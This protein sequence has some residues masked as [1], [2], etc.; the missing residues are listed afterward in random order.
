MVTTLRLAFAEAIDNLRNNFFHTVL[1]VMGMIVGVAALVT[2]LSI[3]DGLELLARRSIADRS[4]VTTVN[5]LQ[6]TTQSLDGLVVPMATTASITSENMRAMLDELPYAATFQLYATND[7]TVTDPHTGVPMGMRYAALSLPILRDV[8]PVVIGRDLTESDEV[9]FAPVIVVNSSLARRLTQEGEL[10][11]AA[12]GRFINIEG[13][14]MEVVGVREP[15]ENEYYLQA[16]M[17]LSVLSRNTDAD[18]STK[19]YID[20][21]RVEDVRPGQT[22]IED[23][24]Q[25][26]YPQI[27]EPVEVKANISAVE[28][29]EEGF[30]LFRVVMGLLIGIAVAVG[31]LG[32]MNVLLMSI[33]NRTP[34]IGIRKATGAT[35]RRILLQFLAESVAISCIGCVFGLI[36]GALL[37]IPSAAIISQFIDGEFEAVFTIRTLAII[38][39]VAIISGIAFGTYPARRAARLDPVAAIQR[40]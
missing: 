25:G 29:L 35:P 10:A 11:Q 19:A 16:E 7:V 20:F 26:Q 33:T 40:S 15:Q 2:M 27:T 30:L 31:G 13:Q 34:E 3:I 32:L 38:S 9:N 36:L 28:D 24:F 21:E 22:F 17:P 4:S 39:V 12:L 37:A 18:Y 23:W 8:A 5:V 6:R 14:D 1:S